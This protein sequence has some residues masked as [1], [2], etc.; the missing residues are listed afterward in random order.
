[1]KCSPEPKLPWAACTYAK[2]LK[3]STSKGNGCAIAL[4]WDWKVGAIKTY[5][6]GCGTESSLTEAKNSCPNQDGA[7]AALRKMCT[8]INVNDIGR[9]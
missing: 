9:W 1:M 3:D 7:N 2:L 4:A 6:H 5:H 8:D